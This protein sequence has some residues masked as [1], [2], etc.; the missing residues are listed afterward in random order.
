M[1]D[2]ST[3]HTSGSAGWRSVV[4]AACATT[5]AVLVVLQLGGCACSASCSSCDQSPYATSEA[6]FD[7]TAERS[8]VL[9]PTMLGTADPTATRAS[10]FGEVSYTAASSRNSADASRSD[11]NLTQVSF[12]AEG[13]ALWWALPAGS[14]FQA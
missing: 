13:I 1:S 4:T 10:I 7:E 12:A 3:I 8:F 6:S 14:L 11:T 2:Q 9:E 5:V